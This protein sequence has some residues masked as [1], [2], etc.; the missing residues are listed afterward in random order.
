[1]EL[2]SGWEK[3]ADN[4]INDSMI[5]WINRRLLLNA[6]MLRYGIVGCSGIAVNLGTMALCLNIGFG[7]GWV[8]SA[9]ASVVSTCGNFIFH[10]CWTFSDRQH[11]GLRLVRGFLSFAIISTIGIFITTEFYVSFTRLASHLAIVTSHLGKLGIPLTCQF[12]AILLGA[13]MSYL[14]NGA[15]TWPRVQSQPS[16]DVAQVTEI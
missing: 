12:A 4:G 2:L 15:V 6:R 16:A 10:N 13:C 5:L 3:K 8:P 14:L 7:R 11:Q 1:M 9:I